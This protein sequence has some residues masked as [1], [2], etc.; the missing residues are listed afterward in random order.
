MRIIVLIMMLYLSPFSAFA[1]DEPIAKHL[2]KVSS[3]LVFLSFSMPEKS[4]E[5]WLLQCKQ[6]GATPVIRGLLNNSFRAT[7]TRIQVLAQKTGMG[8]QLDPI[9]FKTFNVQYVP[10]VVYIKDMPECPSNMNCKPVD[11]DVLYGD[12]TL[13]Y[14]LDKLGEIR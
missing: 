14:A 13:D 7:M 5:A 11:F 12:V 3:V 2:Q 10:A 1:I 9:L 6:I 8:I 4:L